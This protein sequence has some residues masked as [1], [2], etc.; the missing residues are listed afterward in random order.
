MAKGSLTVAGRRRL[1]DYRKAEELGQLSLPWG[2]Q[3]P[4]D[5]TKIAML[6]NS[7]REAA[8]LSEEDARI[9]EMYR[10]FTHGS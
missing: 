7:R 4:R 2:G 10:R 3:S 9:D 5:L 6:L 8:T 1:E